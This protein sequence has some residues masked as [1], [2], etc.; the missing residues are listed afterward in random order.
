MLRTHRGWLGICGV[1]NDGARGSAALNAA[2]GVTMAQN[3]ISSEFFD[4]PAAAIDFGRAQVI[5][6]AAENRC[7]PETPR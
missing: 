1:L 2:G 5:A 6:F 3:E 4:M 7:L